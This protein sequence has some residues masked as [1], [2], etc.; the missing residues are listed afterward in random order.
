MQSNVFK[1]AQAP[2]HGIQC[3]LSLIASPIN[4]YSRT[5]PKK[6]PG[7]TKITSLKIPHV[8][9]A[10]KN[11]W[12]FLSGK[13]QHFIWSLIFK[14]LIRDQLCNDGAWWCSALCVVTADCRQPKSWDPF[15]PCVGVFL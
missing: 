11:N 7:K 1:Y 14:V 4:G 12:S 3:F 13:G 8:S 2:L 9:S 10:T 15:T 5:F 6:C